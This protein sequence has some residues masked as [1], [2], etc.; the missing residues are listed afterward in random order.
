[1]NGIAP[2]SSL[3]W[4]PEQQKM[5]KSWQMLGSVCWRV[6]S[7]LSCPTRTRYESA[8][9]ERRERPSGGVPLVL[10]RTDFPRLLGALE[11]R[12]Y[13]LLGPTVRDGRLSSMK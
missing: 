6:M 4:S 10:E 2:P 12:G 8:D 9:A 3:A 1:M 13:R 7:G 11:V 5:R